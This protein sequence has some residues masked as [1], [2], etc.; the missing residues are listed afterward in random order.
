MQLMNRLKYLYNPPAIIKKLFLDFIWNTSCGKVLLTFDDGP[1]KG[2]SEIILNELNSNKVKAVFFCVGGNVNNNPELTQL[3]LNEGHTIANHTFNHKRLTKI[4]YDE[5][6]SEI[7]LF[8]KLMAE[9]FNYKVKF[10]RPPYGSFKLRTGSLLTGSSLKNV[11]WSLLTYDYKN[12]LKLVKFAV[13]K[14][15][16][17]N[18]IVVLH[19][20]VKSK[21]IIRD[22]IKIIIEAASKKGFKI[23]EP[24]ECLK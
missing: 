19:D 7:V 3:I 11:M 14:Y 10:F 13:E 15:L 1:V 8:N 17:R 23:G 2:S 12:D 6:V 21:N 24:D 18:S 4:S 20:S 5:S 16:E 22:S 9:K